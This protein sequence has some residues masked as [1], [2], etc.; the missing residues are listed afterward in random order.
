[1]NN[2]KNN[3]IYRSRKDRMVAGVMGGL[4][5]YLDV[6]PTIL[7]LIWIGVTAFTGFL[8]GIIAYIIAVLIIP[9]KPE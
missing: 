2:N 7:R 3:K 4:G 1:M 6:D 5:E 8:P 9:L